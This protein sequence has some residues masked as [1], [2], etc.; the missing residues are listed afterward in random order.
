LGP[1]GFIATNNKLL[2]LGLCNLVTKQTVPIFTNQGSTENIAFKYSAE[3]A[4]TIQN[5]KFDNGTE[6]IRKTSNLILKSKVRR[7]IK[8]FLDFLPQTANRWH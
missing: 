8:K 3:D 2:D 5:F 1:S 6:N 7:C 4:A